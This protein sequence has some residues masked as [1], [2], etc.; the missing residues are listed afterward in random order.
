MVDMDR[1]CHVPRHGKYAVCE[2]AHH[3]HDP[4]SKQWQTTLKK[5]VQYLCRGTAEKGIV[6]KE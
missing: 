5:V 2:V 1:H 6:Y 3:A 4:S